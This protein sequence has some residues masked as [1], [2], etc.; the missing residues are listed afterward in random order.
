ME[1]LEPLH[2]LMWRRGTEQVSHGTEMGDTIVI[3][4]YRGRECQGDSCEPE[5]ADQV[6]LPYALQPS[7]L[8]ILQEVGACGTDSC[9]AAVE[10][11]TACGLTQGGSV[12]VINGQYDQAS[13]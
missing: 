2:C 9:P 11:P 10:I 4:Y 3:S 5:G 8:N 6:I 7:I 12:R 1:C 13:G